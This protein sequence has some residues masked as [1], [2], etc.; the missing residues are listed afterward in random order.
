MAFVAPLSKTSQQSVHTSP[1]VVARLEH[2]T[3]SY[4]SPTGGLLEPVLQDV[5]L[6]IYQDDFLGVIG[7]NGGG[8]TTLLKIIL[9]LLEPQ[10]GTV[11][12]FGKSPREVRHLI[13]YVP[14]HARVDTSVS[15]CVLDVVLAGRICHSPWGF[16]YSRA[17]REK[18]LAALR[19]TG[20]A[21]LAHR[22]LATLSGGQRQRVLIARALAAEPKLL[23]LDEPT[24]GI[25][26]YVEQN[27]TDLLHALNE[28]LPI[29]IV[30][31][32]IGFVSTH[33]KRVACLNRRLTVHSAAE[34]TR[35]T[36][37]TFYGEHVHLVQHAPCC[38]L[39]DPGCDHGCVPAHPP[40][41][42][43]MEQP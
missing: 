41:G 34:V 16:L 42:R 35:S 10:Q 25:D 9:G 5:S 20:T 11:S 22:R 19:L 24:A 31:H 17:D 28:R 8:K 38:P 26:P 18:A 23:L 37:A 32:D 30:S 39:N 13:G 2:V 33:L 29:V 40:T 36:M 14:Q 12:V 15:A 7:P 27:L 21:D 6:E 43:K 1:T 3:F 4:R